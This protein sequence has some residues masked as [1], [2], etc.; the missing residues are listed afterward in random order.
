MRLLL[1]R[2]R[3]D[4]RVAIVTYAGESQLLLPSTPVAE[5]ARIRHVLGALHAGGQ[6]NGGAGIELAYVIAQAGFVE[7][8]ANR[9][10]LCTDG[11]F[12]VGVTDADVLSKLAAE[13]AKAQLTLSVFGFGRGYR[14]DAR[15]EAL[16]AQ[17]G[18]HSGYVS[19]RREAE[20]AL[21]E[22][23][24]GLFAPIARDVKLAVA[25]NPAVVASYRLIGYEPGDRPALGETPRP[26]AAAVIGSGHTLTALYEIIPAA[27][28]A[29]GA[30]AT[31]RAPWLNFH[32][33]YQEPAGNARHQLAFPLEQPGGEFSAAS[34][35]FKFAAAVAAFGLILSD[36][37]LKG[38]S[39]LA[40]VAAWAEAGRGD[41]PGGYRSEFIALVRAAEKADP[42]GR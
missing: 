42:A 3:P 18:G 37:P 29:P 21:A 36:S 34:S 41:D 5:S 30:N 8:G 33:D 40:Q 32:V 10:I 27:G 12:N 28:A 1:L 6:T 13:K 39:T 22:E 11:D 9:V 20:R 38:T 2:L 17:G 7:G 24:D 25:F 14:I 4:D 19:T 31:R 23:V 26:D 35:E 15:L 16:A